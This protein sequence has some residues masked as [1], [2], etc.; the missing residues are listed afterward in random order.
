MVI[1]I[2]CPTTKEARNMSNEQEE[3]FNALLTSLVKAAQRQGYAVAKSDQNTTDQ[4][5]KIMAGLKVTLAKVVNDSI[6][7]AYAQGISDACCSPNHEQ[8]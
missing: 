5:N 4:I 8:L 1:A 6:G 7:A 3:R 2:W